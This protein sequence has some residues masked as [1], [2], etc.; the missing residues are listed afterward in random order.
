MSVRELT[1]LL[2]W[3]SSSGSALWRYYI[4]SS[5]YSIFSTRSSIE[6]EYEG[7]SFSMWRI[8]RTC[9]IQSLRSPRTKILCAA[10]GIHTLKPEARGRKEESRNLNVDSSHICF[11][12]YYTVVDVYE[13][14]TQT[15]TI[16]V[17]DPESSSKEELQWT[18][19]RPSQHSR[20]LTKLLNTL[21]QQP[22]IH[23][24]VKKK[25]Y[26]PD[27]LTADGTWVVSLPMSSDD[28]MKEIRGNKVAFQ[29][30]FIAN[31]A[32]LLTFPV[33]TIAET[34]GDLPLT[35]PP[36][37]PLMSTWSSC[38]PT[39]AVLLT[40]TETF[41]TN[42][43]FRTWTRIRVPPGILSNAQRR[44]VSDVALFN[45]GIMFLINGAIYL[46]TRR[47]FEKLDSSQGV[48]ETEIIGIQRRR[49]CPVRYLLKNA[50]K[51]S[52]L[53]IWTKSEF[54]LGYSEFR[55]VKIMDSSRLKAALKLTPDDTVVIQSVEYTWHP[56]ELALLLYYCSSCTT[57]KHTRMLLY[58]EDS[59][60][61]TIQ[62][63]QLD[64]PMSSNLVAHFL[65]SALP[66]LILWDAHRVYY[67]YRNFTVSGTMRVKEGEENL[68]R[69]SGGSKIHNV[70][71]DRFGS[72]LIKMENNVMFF[73][74][75]DI[76][77][78]IKLHI[79]ANSTIKS[80][81][82]FN[83]S[84]KV[85]LVYFSE[86]YLVQRQEY[87]LFL[88]IES[89]VYQS[90]DQCPYLAF[91]H[92]IFSDFYFIDKGETLTI[93]TQIV[94]PENRG[95][96]IIVEHYGPKILTWTQ[97]LSYEIASGLCT[98]S[99]YTTFS[100]TTNYKSVKDY[101]KLEDKNTGLMLVQ[102]RPS[103][104]SKTCPM[105]KQ[106]FEIAVG[107]DANKHIQVR[108]FN[109]TGC[110][111]RDFSYVIDKE[112]LRDSPPENVK[113][114]YDVG[115]YGCPRRL[116]F[117]EPFHPII[118][119]Y[120]ENGFVKIV[121]ANFIVW[122]IHG[123]ND[124]TFNYTMKQSGCINEAQTLKSMIEENKDL[125]LDD[126]W[127]PQ[128]YKTCFSY[129]IGKPGDLNQP[130]EILN[131]SNKNHLLWPMD[132]SGMYVFRVKI[133]DPNFSFCN[134]TSIFAIETF[135]V[136]PSPSVY[137]VVAFLFVLM[138]TFISILVLSYFWYTKIYRQFIFEPLHKPPTKLKKN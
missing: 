107:C 61:W 17:Y 8:S 19:T 89:S 92:N 84:S 90:D 111:R 137:L 7:P 83:K 30:C 14:L 73:S 87:P 78:I 109:R 46:K 114:R 57:T 64:L 67:Y 102:F 3:L 138:L 75:A 2:W 16:W 86:N 13:N 37:S 24:L 21:G 25:V 59:T 51:K 106:V 10:P 119:L 79:W 113:I 123:R 55:F 26:V 96:S 95:L 91:Q 54:Y 112:Y 9:K 52:L 41:Q 76:T 110:H 42:N 22:Y 53:A 1:V 103:E 63:F 69:L 32:F 43:S 120:D 56:L 28:L 35:L 6:I 129:A 48:P 68:S 125:P 77:N 135:G 60:E 33:M 117:N 62:D 45:N 39:F 82:F 85:Y 38:I 115:K 27:A 34:P 127:G 70:I 29:D 98:K 105:A 88:E 47:T 80:A 50:K 100:Q 99:M 116:E 15:V 131:H 36:G 136:I 118:E 108:G 134:L 65:Y 4:N 93:W 44:N 74:K 66:D 58:N 18:A 101:F 12:W 132:H 23:T 81:L 72:I 40:D 133:L 5:D 97:D 121:E 31:L 126:V 104:F 20:I 11:M 124:Y 122:E 130:Y 94:Y 71:V 128:N 49:W